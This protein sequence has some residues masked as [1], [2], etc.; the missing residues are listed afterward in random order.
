MAALQ[1][2]FGAA[3]WLLRVGSTS[4]SRAEA[5]ADTANRVFSGLRQLHL[6]QRP[7]VAAAV[8]VTNGSFVEVSVST[9]AGDDWLLTLETV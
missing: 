7:L 8:A 2:A 3:H 1:P 9:R 6:A 4:S 5:V